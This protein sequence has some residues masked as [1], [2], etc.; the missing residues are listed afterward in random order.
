MAQ[1]FLVKIPDR[2]FVFG[3]AGDRWHREATF[4]G[5]TSE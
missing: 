5:C 4:E 1:Q 2:D 3:G